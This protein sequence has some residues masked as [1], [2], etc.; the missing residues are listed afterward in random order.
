MES[1]RG[2]FRPTSGASSRLMGSTPHFTTSLIA[3]PRAGRHGTASSRRSRLP[4]DAG[5]PSRGGGHPLEGRGNLSPPAVQDSAAA[6]PGEPAFL[7]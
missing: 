2:Q 5:Q 7:R 3:L 6:P 4:C 1:K